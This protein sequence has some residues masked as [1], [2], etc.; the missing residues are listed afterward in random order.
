VNETADVARLGRL[1]AAPGRAA[2]LDVLFDGRAWSVSELADAVGISPSTASEQLQTL[3]RGGLVS[4]VRDGRHRRYRLASDEIAAALESLSTLAPL[5][6]S[7][8]LRAIT[9]TE[10]MRAA[11]TCYDHLAGT[12]GVAVSEGLVHAGVVL[13]AEHSFAPTRHGEQVLE[14][15]G[16]DMVALSRA[17][18]PTTLACLD[19]SERRPHLA[20]GLGAALLHRLETLG[21]IERLAPGRAIRLR[22][23]GHALLGRLGVTVGAG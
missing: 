5:Q 17:K 7:R 9:R 8:G 13:P 16:I 23:A 15:A 19:W 20:G 11:R 22:P 2:M 3:E 10:A 6:A 18:R 21:G 14:T 1:L 4:S 12:L